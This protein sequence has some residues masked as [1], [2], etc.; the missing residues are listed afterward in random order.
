MKTCLAKTTVTIFALGSGV[1]M[2]CLQGQTPTNTALMVTP[3]ITGTS[4]NPGNYYSMCAK[5]LLW[6][7]APCMYTYGWYHCLVNISGSI[8][9]VLMAVL[10]IGWILFIITLVGH[11][12]LSMQY[13]YAVNGRFQELKSE[14][15]YVIDN[16]TP[17]NMLSMLLIQETSRMHR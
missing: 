13:W 8:T 5:H 3:S 9:T 14:C 7:G 11:V 12:L 1:C 4:T 15:V 2:T 6:F 17:V 10:V 16:I